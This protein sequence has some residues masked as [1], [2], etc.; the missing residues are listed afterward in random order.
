MQD[1]DHWA[2]LGNIGW[3]AKDIQAYGNRIKMDFRPV[4]RKDRNIAASAWVESAANATRAKHVRD[5]NAETTAE[6]GI[7]NAVGF[8][9]VAY[10]PYT[11]HRYSASVA[12]LHPIMGV[13]QNLHL[14]LDTWAYRLVWDETDAKMIRGVRARAKHGN[15]ILKARREVVLS[16]GAIDS[17]RLL[18]LSGI[19][20]AKE[21]EAIGINSAFDLPGVGENLASSQVVLV[22]SLLIFIR[23]TM[24]RPS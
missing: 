4:A 14:F 20:P 3:G 7:A 1:L 6:E 11:G 12:Y 23:W 21:L 19:G 2:D 16:A 8:L 13:R 15:F 9:S 5:F 17:P 10:D 18:L 24:S 22:L